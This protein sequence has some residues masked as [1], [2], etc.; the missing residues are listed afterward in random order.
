M[1]GDLLGLTLAS[2]RGYTGNAVLVLPSVRGE[3]RFVG[4]G[5]YLVQA[6]GL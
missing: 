5:W 1:H 2:A 4:G 6:D 3:I